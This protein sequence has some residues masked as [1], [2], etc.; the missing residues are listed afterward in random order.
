[1]KLQSFEVMYQV[2]NS[3]CKTILQ[4]YEEGSESQAISK[5]RSRGTIKAGINVIIHSIKKK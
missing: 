2:N 5:L 4:M 3:R 1:M